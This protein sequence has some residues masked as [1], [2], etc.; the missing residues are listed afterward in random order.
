MECISNFC[1]LKS[2]LLLSASPHLRACCQQRFSC[3]SPAERGE[4]NYHTALAIWGEALYAT[5]CD[6]PENQN[7]LKFCK[8]LQISKVPRSLHQWQSSCCCQ[9]KRSPQFQGDLFNVIFI[10]LLLR[11]RI[12]IRNLCYRFNRRLHFALCRGL[13]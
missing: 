13:I 1:R 4:M 7:A 12:S 10:F 6:A 11:C 2:I 8:T 3:P 5:I 9:K